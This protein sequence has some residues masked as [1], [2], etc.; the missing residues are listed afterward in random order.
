MLRLRPYK[1]EDAEKIL[2]WCRTEE[3]FYKWTAGILG[4]Y[5]ISKEQFNSVNSLMA[6]TAID[7]NEIVG[8]FTMRNPVEALDELRFGFVIVDF[9]KRGKGY[10]KA[11]LLL[12]LKYAKEIYGA[13]K[14]ALGVFENN[15]SAY[16]CYKAVGFKDVISDEVETYNILG[17]E[18]NCLVLDIQ[19]DRLEPDNMELSQYFKSIIDED[20]C[21]VVICNLEHEII[22]MNPVACERY[23]KWG[24][25]NLV[26]RN[27]LNCHNSDSV[28]KINK[29]LDWFRESREN[30]RMYT[31]H[32][33]KENKDVYMIALRDRKG[34][35]IGYYEK[36]EYR[37]R[38]QGKTYDLKKEKT[39]C[40]HGYQ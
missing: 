28:D 16:H 22:Y 7:G 6:F 4:D 1:E 12:G 32:N 26:G 29:V 13:K 25:Q 14:V 30:N 17:E 31:Y 36:H 24:G 34:E 23:V 5:P 37:N 35:L 15:K 33:E 20:N 19:L 2:S 9:E 18:W 38:E 21:A 39:T 10:G 3:E 11:M 40:C 8:F 27:L